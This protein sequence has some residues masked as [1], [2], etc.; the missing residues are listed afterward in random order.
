[1]THSKI[2]FLHRIAPGLTA[3]MG[4]NGRGVGMGSLMGKVA[5]ETILRKN[6]DLSDFPVT[7]PRGFALHRFHGTGVTMAVKW[8]ALL[9]YLDSLQHRP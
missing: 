1:M 7:Y 2:P 3:A 6:D 9:D 4:Y 8:F 5:A